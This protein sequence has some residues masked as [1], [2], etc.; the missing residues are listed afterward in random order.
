MNHRGRVGLH[1]KIVLIGLSWAFATLQ[2][3]GQDFPKSNPTKDIAAALALAKRDGKPILL[4]FGADWCIDCKVLEGLFRD[5]SVAPF[6]RDHFHVVKI[7]LG[8]YFM[9]DEAARNPEVAK[10]YGIDPMASGVPALVLLDP[11]GRIVPVKTYVM[12]RRSREFDAAG[13]LVHLR[14]LANAVK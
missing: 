3:L 12:W 10:K 7:D 13:V 14:E 8:M 4:D 1:A 5:P 9:S 11:R 6:L 2:V